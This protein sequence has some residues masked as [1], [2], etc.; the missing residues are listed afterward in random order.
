MSTPLLFA[1]NTNIWVGSKNRQK[2]LEISEW[3]IHKGEIWII[4]G[5]NGSG[6]TTLLQTITGLIPNIFGGLVEGKLLL[7]G[8]NPKTDF[9]TI[10]EKIAFLFQ[11]PHDQ[12]TQPTVQSEIDFPLENLG[13][14]RREGIMRR[15]RVLKQFGF[16]KKR[17]QHPIS[18][19]TGEAQ[20]LMMASIATREASLICLDEPFSFTDSVERKRISNWI[21]EQLGKQKTF[22]IATHKP[23]EYAFLKPKLLF[24]DNGRGMMFETIEAFLDNAG[25]DQVLQL[26]L[27]TQY[28]FVLRRLGRPHKW[29][30]APKLIVN[31]E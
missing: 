25:W 9:P 7:F 16:Q 5:G 28:N 23:E 1:R 4:I 15:E 21:T 6:K 19:S 31:G 22:I 3:E 13:Y 27:P 26:S 14:A 17:N 11:N 2:V 29:D 12:I 20:R 24:L 10:F 30:P 18:L 8:K